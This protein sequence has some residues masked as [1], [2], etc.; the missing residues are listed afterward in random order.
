MTPE[1]RNSGSRV[2]Y[3]VK[4]R[5]GKRV[6]AAMNEQETIEVLMSYNDENG[7]FCWVRPEAI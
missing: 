6:P 7:V 5:L 1:S 3:V 2:D 4:K